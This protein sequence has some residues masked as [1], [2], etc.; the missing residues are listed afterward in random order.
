MDAS[1]LISNK[2]ITA[3][4][5][6]AMFAKLEECR[7]Q[8]Y[9]RFQAEDVIVTGQEAIY[10]PGSV[11]RTMDFF[12][13]SYR[14]TVHYSD[15]T[16]RD[17][18]NYRDFIDDFDRRLSSIESIYLYCHISYADS[19]QY[20]DH[21]GNND[22]IYRGSEI[23]MY[24]RL[25]SLRVDYKPRN[26]DPVLDDAYLLIQQKIA[27]AP[28]RYDRLIKS[29]AIIGMRIGFAITAIPTAILLAALIAVPQMRAIFASTYVVYPLVTIFVA[30]V[31]GSVIGSSMLERYYRH[32]QPRQRYSGYDRNNHQAIYSDDINDYTEKG[33]VLIGANANNQRDRQAII[34]M[35]KHYSHFIPA[36]LIVI[37]V[38]SI[39]I[40]IVGKIWK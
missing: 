24:I 21:G 25:D 6:R 34:N 12:Q 40:I 28:E 11:K 10:G 15:S 9:Q 1:S 35:E 19:S 33:E 30:L 29:R 22:A 38:L 14:A 36:C 5:L 20:N 7:L 26:N 23:N 8:A 13:S 3:N 4:D 31:G 27:E 39:A 32:I 16:S 37:S 2:I 17:Y 18:S